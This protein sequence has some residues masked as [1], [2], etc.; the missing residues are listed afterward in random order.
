M[1]AVLDEADLAP[2]DARA[3]LTP[4]R[5][6]GHGRCVPVCRRCA[7]R[8]RVKVVPTDAQIEGVETLGDLLDAVAQASVM[9]KG[10]VRERQRPSR[11]S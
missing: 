11:D 3:E 1:E 7:R 8:T 2:A 6:S 10:R 5:G 9:T 4:A